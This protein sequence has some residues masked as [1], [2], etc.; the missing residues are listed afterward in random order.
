MEKCANLTFFPRIPRESPDRPLFWAKSCPNPSSPQKPCALV[1]AVLAWALH[2]AS[3][4]CLATPLA[5]EI[6]VSPSPP[7][8]LLCGDVASSNFPVFTSPGSPT[9]LST[10]KSDKTTR[11]HSFFNSARPVLVPGLRAGPQIHLVYITRLFLSPNL[12]RLLLSLYLGMH[13][14]RRVIA[15]SNVIFCELDAIPQ[16][17]LCSRGVWGMC[18][19]SAC[20]LSAQDGCIRT[21]SKPQTPS[22]CSPLPKSQQRISRISYHS[23]C[24]DH[25]LDNDPWPWLKSQPVATGYRRLSMAEKYPGPSPPF[26]LYILCGRGLDALTSASWKLGFQQ[27]HS[28]RR[29]PE[30]TTLP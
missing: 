17:A 12:W 30:R 15:R 10:R 5:P 13:I 7:W 21:S 22:F 29:S 18:M 9:P 27:P 26:H 3:D 28:L 16:E 2:S 14:P 8:R 1:V 23:K 19:I 20:L 6:G 24:H 4:R 11:I 25:R